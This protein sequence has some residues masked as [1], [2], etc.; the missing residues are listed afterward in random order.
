MVVASARATEPR[1]PQRQRGIDSAASGTCS[2]HFRSTDGGFSQPARECG[3]ET[4]SGPARSACGGY[5]LHA[6]KSAHPRAP[7]GLVGLVTSTR[8][9]KC[10]AEQGAASATPSG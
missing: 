3:R 9:E 7:Y 8:F 10:A 1:E 5:W 4:L 6:S 2:H